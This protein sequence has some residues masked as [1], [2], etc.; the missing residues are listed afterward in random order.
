[1]QTLAEPGTVVVTAR[2]QRQAAGLFIAEERGT[3]QLKGAPEPVMLLRIVRA[4][5][6]RR[7][8]RQRNLAPLVGRDEELSILMRR[9]E[10]SR[11]GDGQLVTIVGE[12]GLGK[13]V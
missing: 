6:G 8:A 11:H 10:R 7:R 2:V 4:S 12:P 3:H 1:V 5:G 9:W 13:L